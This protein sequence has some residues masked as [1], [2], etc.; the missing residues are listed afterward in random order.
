MSYYTTNLCQNPSFQ[1]GL[2][3]YSPILNAG[4]SLDSSRKL[5]GAQKSLL[6][7]TPG[8]IAGE[9]VITAGGLIT[10]ADTCSASIYVQG[11]GSINVSANVNPGGIVA[12]TTPVTLTGEWQRVMLNNIQCTPGQTLYITAY[13]TMTQQI[14]FWI[15]GIQVEPESPAHPY[16][17]GNQAGCS[18]LS[19]PPGIS[20][21][22][23]QFPVS[24]A[25]M[26]IAAG[27]IVQVLNSGEV[28]F[29]DP[30]PGYSSSYGDKIFTG[31][32]EPVGAFDDFAIFELTD[33]DP[34]QTY[35]GINNAGSN[36]GTSG[37][38]NRIFSTFYPPL[39]YNVSNEQILWNRA[40]FAAIGF[41]F[42]SVPSSGT[43]NIS[44]IQVELLPITNSGP[45][46]YTLPRQVET[47]VVPDRLNYCTNPSFET[48]T[49]FWSALG[50]ASISVDNTVYIGTVT[51]HDDVVS[52]SNQSMNIEL[53]SS[54]DGASIQIAE[55]IVGH[56]YTI[57]SYI[58]VSAG[59]SDVVITCGDGASS[60]VDAGSVGYGDGEYGQD[61]YGGLVI[62]PG[63]DLAT[64]VWYR[65]F[66]TF[67]AQESTETFFV[68]FVPGSD[69]SYPA[70]LWIDAVLIEIGETVGPYFDGNFGTGYYWENEPSNALVPSPYPYVIGSTSDSNMTTTQTI[71]TPITTNA[72]DAIVVAAS[73]QTTTAP[74][75]LYP[76]F[77]IGGLPEG[78]VTWTEVETA[79]SAEYIPGWR[80]YNTPSTGGGTGVPTSWPGGSAGS[81][82]GGVTIPVVSIKPNVADVLA[83]TLDTQLSEWFAS[84]PDG[85]VV[86]LWHEGETSGN[87]PENLIAMHT[88]AFSLFNESAPSG[89]FYAQIFTNY[90][91]YTGSAHYPLNQWVCCA[92][93]GGVQLDM[94]GFDWYPYTDATDAVN[95]IEPAMT[96][97][98]SVAP[99]DSVICIPECN[100]TTGGGITWTGTQEQWFT[101]SWTWATENSAYFFFPYYDN[102]HGVDWPPDSGTIS[103]LA[104]MYGESIGSLPAP[105]IYV[106]GST[107]VAA[108]VSSGTCDITTA[109]NPG[110]NILVVF[111]SN[112]GPFSSI[113][114]TESNS[115]TTVASE[116]SEEKLY[117]L[118]ATGTVMELSTS[119]SVTIHWTGTAS[120]VTITV[121]GISDLTLNTPD[122]IATAFSAGSSTPSVTSAT[123]SDST[124]ICV[125]IETNG[126]GGGAISWAGGWTSLSSQQAP[127][128]SQYTGVA[129]QE[130]SSASP[131]TASGTLS[132]SIKWGIILLTFELPPPASTETVTG[133]TDSQGNTYTQVVSNNA[134]Y[135]GAAFA[136]LNTTP[137]VEDTDYI[138]VTYSSSAGVSKNSAAMGCSNIITVLAIDQYA[139]N[140]G[141]STG[142]SASTGALSQVNEIAFAWSTNETGEITWDR[143][144][145]PQITGVFNDDNF[146]SSM[147]TQ[148]L[149]SI[150]EITASG[151]VTPS[152]DWTMLVLTLKG[153]EGEAYAGIN[154]SRSYFYDQYALKQQG[155]INALDTHTPLGIS[156]GE[157]EY[158]VPYI[159]A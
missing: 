95:S 29:A 84:V 45:T 88:H 60:I 89:A 14:V 140:S 156:H 34:A 151:G 42:T 37:S 59:I 73:I 82:P 2:N 75:P 92:A 104:T 145:V 39:Q 30:L 130:V 7:Q 54:A 90:T 65:P 144:W 129:Y 97:F 137:L 136:A 132:T 106:M 99:S 70:N 86:T 35:P 118:M 119:D 135:N 3:G 153:Q 10:T 15:S 87:S 62:T 66:F 124:E 55:L 152:Q 103:Q 33:L 127:A 80:G 126:A 143:E 64:E 157:P 91:S 117:A 36:S 150:E 17:D 121:L 133:V 67:T 147:S 138:T 98:F 1:N 12:G 22:E 134:V 114:D 111:C 109:S 41:E 72:G 100:Y 43:Q 56:Q 6:V 27:N 120:D 4:I 71:T 146:V 94:Y 101:D 77:G 107:T 24:A 9:G 51:E 79:L 96:Q 38:Y 139:N 125:A 115:Y 16:C 25:G 83:G 78:S 141:L 105:G 155:V 148:I 108:G 44:D 58:Q 57:S 110:D 8:K 13:T 23:Y 123:L 149:D 116:T 11:T 81:I 131:V 50:E 102:A 63:M 19:G 20:I 128:G 31:L 26:T 113:Y 47:I 21:Q 122:Q 154:L 32:I 18:W 142:P 158:L 68:T 85:A 52:G 48:S 74:P 46:A 69:I 53:H 40:A 61:P 159:A 93:N 28:F 76:L 49:E 5:F 112:S